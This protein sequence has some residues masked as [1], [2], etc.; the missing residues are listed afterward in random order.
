MTI[1]HLNTFVNR[2]I[3]KH[4]L[5]NRTMKTKSKIRKYGNSVVIKISKDDRERLEKEGIKV[6]D[7][8]DV[9]INKEK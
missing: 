1:K 6:G 3:F 2:N 8:V 4:C 5:F 9:E 7:F